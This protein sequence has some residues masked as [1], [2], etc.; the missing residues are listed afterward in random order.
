[1][2]H[3]L[4]KI[5]GIREL[6]TLSVALESGADFI[7]LVHFPKSPRHLNVHELASLIPH[8]KSPAQSVIV[9]V[10]PTDAMLDELFSLSTPDYI[11]LH[12]HEA[13]ERVLELKTKYGAKIIKAIG[14]QNAADI[15][16]AQL[17]AAIADIILFDAKPAKNAD[18]AGGLGISFDWKLLDEWSKAPTVPWMLSGGLSVDN[19]AAALTITGAPMVDASSHLEEPV[20]SGKK[21]ADKIRGFIQQVK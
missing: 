14:V 4:I 12:G 21:S 13:P 6:S 9:C 5:C 17:Y 10:D 19:V 18:N 16:Q 20:G 15:S 8:I 7:G 11:Q 1:M 2:S 3:S